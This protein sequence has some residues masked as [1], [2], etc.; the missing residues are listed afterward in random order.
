MKWLEIS[1][2]DEITPLAKFPTSSIYSGACFWQVE[3]KIDFKW[4]ILLAKD[5]AG[6]WNE[7]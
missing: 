4:K 6:F 2:S 5:L 7:N 1:K 3:I